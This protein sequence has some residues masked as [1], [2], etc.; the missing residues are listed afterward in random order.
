MEQ[1]QTEMD[2]KLEDKWVIAKMQN[3][4]EDSVQEKGQEEDSEIEGLTKK[5]K[6]NFLFF[7]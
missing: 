6:P 7:K 3:P 1:D 5:N 2:P 4:R